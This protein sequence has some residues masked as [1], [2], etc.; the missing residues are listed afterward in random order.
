MPKAMLAATPPRR[1]SSSSTRNDS[2]SLSSCST[3]SE[4]ANRPGKVMRWSVAMEP[5]IA[6]RTR[7]PYRARQVTMV[8]EYWWVTA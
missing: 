3:T 8:L 4:S 2:E 7:R 1:T 6:I 5:V